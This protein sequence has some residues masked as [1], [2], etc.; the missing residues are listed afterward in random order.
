MGATT[1]A[2]SVDAAPAAASTPEWS[3]PGYPAAALKETFERE[4]KKLLACFEPGRKRNPQL[5]GRV[6]VRFTLGTNGRP[7]AVANQGSN[8]EDD[9]VITCV[10][11]VVKGTHFPPTQEGTVT[12]V[13]PFIFHPYEPFLILPESAPAPGP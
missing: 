4:Q 9:A 1:D 8:L 10:V 6:I 7:K 12:I 3:A 2:G 5:R 11:K 13:Y